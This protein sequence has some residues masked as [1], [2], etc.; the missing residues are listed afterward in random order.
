MSKGEH[1]YWKINSL[2]FLILIYYNI[3]DTL[4]FNTPPMLSVSPAAPQPVKVHR[5]KPKRM[6]FENRLS[7]PNVAIRM[8]SPNLSP[9][10][11]TSSVR[12]LN[13][14][15][16]RNK[17]RGAR[18]GDR[19]IEDSFNNVSFISPMEKSFRAPLNDHLDLGVLLKEYDL[20]ELA[21]VLE[22]NGVSFR[23]FCVCG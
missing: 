21:P 3:L 14:Q 8:K 5:K 7:T 22:A 19:S 23:L 18:L 15:S 20:V 6:S 2:P 1:R 12:S 13:F 17:N 11:A 9:I 10:P 16:P 4:K